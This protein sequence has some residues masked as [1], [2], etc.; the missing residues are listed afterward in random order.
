MAK[1]I[2]NLF[3]WA[4]FPFE[5]AFLFPGARRKVIAR[6]NAGIPLSAVNTTAN[7]NTT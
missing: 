3:Q 2:E 1:L 6:H 5:F 7:H 4:L